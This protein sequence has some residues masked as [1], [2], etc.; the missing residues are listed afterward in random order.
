MSLS[1]DANTG[2][3]AVDYDPFAA[4]ALAR[5]VPSTEAQREV[6]LAAKLGTE[7]SLAYNEAVALTLRGALDHAAL[8]AALQ[9][10]VDR[11]DAL[12]A[13]FGPEGETFCVAQAQA[14][15]LPVSDVS[16]A[17]AV[18]RTAALDAARAR[19]VGQP[20]ALETGPLLR[21]ELVRLAGDEHVLFLCAHH[22][23]CD[24]WSW[25]V[26][27]RELGAL[28]AARCGAPS[29]AAAWPAAPAFADYALATAGAA[30][31]AK[32]DADAAWWVARY[33]TLPAPLDLP[34][35]H[36]RPPERRFDSA[37]VDVTLDAALLGAVRKLGAH[38]GVSLF[39][40]LLSAFAGTLGRLAGNDEV[41]LGI[42]AAA[43]ASE[44]L[45]DLVGHG[46]HLLPL[47][48]PAAPDQPF[49][50]LLKATSTELL[51]AL[52]H[53]RCTFGHLVRQLDLPRDP[54]RTPLVHVM[55]NIDQALDQQSGAFPGLS[56]AF[57]SVPRRFENFEL[58]VNAVQEHGGLRLECQYATGLFD[59]ST[60]RR[61]M[62]VFEVLLRAAVVAPATALGKLPLLDA[63]ALAALRA[64]Q[65][66]PRVWAD[67]PCMQAAFAR[68]A[69][70]APDRVALTVGAAKLSYR[71]L[72][73]RANVIAHGLIGLGVKPGALVGVALERGVDLLAAVLGVLK[74]GAGYVPLDPG[75]PIERLD[76]MAKDAGLAA[77]LTQADQ[78]ARFALGDCP[79]VAL[80]A[81][82]A[83]WHGLPSTAPVVTI[84][85]DA[86]AYVIYTSGSTGKPKG[87]AIPHRAAANF[88]ASMLRRP[89]IK[90]DDR[91]LAVTTLS[92]DIAVLELFGPL[93]AGAEVVL[94]THAQA[95]DGAALRELIT[96]HG[97]TVM[98][99]TPATWRLLLQAGWAGTPG[100]RALCGGEALAP[101]LAAALTARC[102]EVWNMYGPTETTVWS[103][104]ARVEPGAPI[105]I[106]TPID[107][108]TVWVRDAR[109]E[110]CPA[111]VPGELWIGGTG[112]SSG[113]L[114]RP[115]LTAER[116]VADPFSD[117]PGARLYRT[118]D[119]GRWLADGQLEHRGRADFQIKLRGF[120]IEPG[121]IETRLLAQP[122]VREAVVMAREDR[123]G[124][125]RLVAYV[126]A[127]G[128]LDERAVRDAL[129]KDLPDYMLPQHVVALAALPRLP[130]GKLDR[131]HLPVPQPGTASATPR[132]APRDALEQT[133]ASA[134]AEVLG[135]PVVGRDEDFFAL[136]GHSLLAAQLVARLHR[137]G[138]TMLSLRHIFEAP[139]V[140]RLAALVR[141]GAGATTPS[142]AI[143][144]R[145][146]RTRAPLSLMQQR[147]WYL[148]QMHPGSVAWHTPSAHRLRG[149]MDVRAFTHALQVVVQRQAV[150]RTAIIADGEGVRQQI[151]P[152][153]KAELPVEDL[154]RVPAA[155]REGELRQRLDALIAEPFDLTV[156]PLFRVRLFRLAADDHVFFFMT[157]H[158][159]WDGWSF[160]L[161]YREMSA[162]YAAF[163]AGRPD[164]LPPLRVDYGDFAAWQREWLRGD[165]LRQQMA[166]WLTRLANP[167]APLQLPA[168]HPR[169]ARMSG[170]GATEWVRLPA[171]Q[172]Q[173][174]HALARQQATTPFVVLL[175]AFAALLARLAG[176]RDL[177]ISTPVRNRGS[178][179]LEP[180]MGFFVNALPLRIRLD[181]AATF[182]TLVDV[183][184]G[185][186]REAL[187]APDVPFEELVRAL[188]LPH[189]ESR[190][191]LAQ[192]MFS[193]QDVR[194]RVTTWGTLQHEH[195]PV[196]QRG[197]AEDLGLW[198]IEQDDG[199]LGGMS[200]NTD[201]FAPATAVRFRQMYEALLA[202]VLTGPTAPLAPLR[203]EVPDATPVASA[204]VSP[205]AAQ[206]PAVE[207]ARVMTPNEVRLASIWRALI[208]VDGIRPEDN[209]FDLGGHSLLAVEMVARVQ[210]EFGVRLNLIDIATGTLATL[211]AGLPSGSTPAKAGVGG[212]IMHWLHRT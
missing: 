63:H 157:H 195:L 115:E 118:G 14:I 39:A 178:A 96:A 15:A 151:L 67:A 129:R 141:A 53:A 30:A 75:F 126:V 188:H 144:R 181:D 135:C 64:W 69:H 23:V 43:Q 24:G 121:E 159:I 205:T 99:A 134:M 140:A 112:V 124:D 177:V 168:D 209:F 93:S 18:A 47:R 187:A 190:A 170:R 80:D 85:A 139:T 29:P 51:D 71:A 160:D 133:M 136:G 44:G 62:A 182:A 202:A 192:A 153:V 107:N 155:R 143:A 158:I 95:L 10:L 54:S 152:Q 20:F 32:A 74:A 91:L 199:L 52:D 48:C 189:D 94:A 127:A 130:N 60:I 46:V 81:P 161:L 183:V 113:Y 137:E 9:A 90:A 198:F 55:F 86:T 3:V 123:V 36:P 142:P 49:G 7:A 76:Y 28:Y 201:V 193:F 204:E 11:H 191:P 100:L 89:G 117:L 12:R 149:A 79:V 211:A 40:T 138:R 108:T 8:A 105:T 186:V 83:A 65:P 171:T 169:P 131:A 109:G 122:G 173:A 197:S 120:R 33:A 150:L 145:P 184:G 59:E 2:A 56:L 111:G 41:V 26:I 19:M 200:Y 210:R 207:P 185:V 194:G 66:A 6:W 17:D 73:E 78:Q 72:D 148:E 162:L 203:V 57:A 21:A 58:S 110:L 132:E 101:D 70:A 172:L 180:V 104:C 82:P 13:T 196:F 16:A 4:P 114:H 167:P 92:F 50:A 206:A 97:I 37:R 156:A 128:A 106:G 176:Q 174:V 22:L 77:L 5:V 212:R 179:D 25:W 147:V 103:T 27:V 98:Q 61:W 1:V 31:R 125:A 116:F 38:H 87:V 175:A 119:R 68:Q 45:G 166:P 165:V 84:A 34:L 102:G 154:Q 164:P 35:D 146:D 88:L 42:P 208:G 163:V